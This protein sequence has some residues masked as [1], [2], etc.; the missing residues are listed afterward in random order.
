[1]LIFYGVSVYLP[2]EKEIRKGGN[3]WSRYGV[4]CLLICTLCTDNPKLRLRILHVTFK[5]LHTSLFRFLPIYMRSGI[6]ELLEF[7][8]R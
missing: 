7:F 6:A 8:L 1:M 4:L 5:S 3:E 2:E